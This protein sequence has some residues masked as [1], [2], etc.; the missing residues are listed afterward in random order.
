MCKKKRSIDLSFQIVCCNAILHA[1]MPIVHW[2]DLGFRLWRQRMAE[3]GPLL[4]CGQAVFAGN[5]TAALIWRTRIVAAVVQPLGVPGRGIAKMQGNW[6]RYRPSKWH[7]V[8][9][10]PSDKQHIQRAPTFLPKRSGKAAI[11]SPDTITS[12]RRPHPIFSAWPA[13]PRS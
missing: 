3:V 13:S 4:P 12:L 8:G 10:R 1:D 6:P 2:T 7:W 9:A 5:S 11:T